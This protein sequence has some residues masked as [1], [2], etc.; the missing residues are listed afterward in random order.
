MIRSPEL[1]FKAQA[2]CLDSDP[3]KRV[4]GLARGVGWMDMDVNVDVNVDVDLVLT[5]SRWLD[6]WMD[7]WTDER[8]SR[9]SRVRILAAA[10]QGAL[11]DDYAGCGRVLGM[12]KLVERCN[13]MK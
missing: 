11:V 12:K 5:G 8:R 1:C 6:G 7:R 13:R 3:D 9:G 10:G 4:V 2:K